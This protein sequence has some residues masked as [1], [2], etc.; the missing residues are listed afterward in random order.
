[1]IKF[2]KEEGVENPEYGTPLSS[3]M[4][5][6][7]HKILAV[8][9]GD[10]LISP[11]NLEKVQESFNERGYIKLRSLERILFGTGLRVVMPED[12][13]VQVRSRSGLALKRGLMVLNSPG[14]VDADY[15]G[16]IGIIL[17]NSTPFLNMVE[18]GE[19]IAQLVVSKVER[20][21]IM[22][23]SQEDFDKLETI[24]AEGGFGSTGNK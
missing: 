6:K 12:C 4:D 11:E 19:R 8:Y 3:G 9:R 17:Y 5:V 10:K 1:M 14:T 13:E 7:A 23:I 18:K 16:E 21:G 22:S 20:P 2:L 15:K 24:R